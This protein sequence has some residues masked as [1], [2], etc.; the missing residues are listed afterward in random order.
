MAEWI[1]SVHNRTQADV[2]HAIAL[3]KA[4]N[5]LSDHKGCFNVSDIN[6][7]ENNSRY[8][9][10]RLN[11]LKYTNTIET[12]VWDMYGVPNVTEITRLINNVAKIISAYYKPADA[13]NLP[14]TLLTFEQVNA[15]EKNL[16]LIKHLI[17]D[18]E[19]QYRHCGTFNCGEEW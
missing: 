3:L 7:I 8:I 14:N 18:E 17:D 19:N 9:A 10:D 16:Y 1:S 4:G 15:L 2:E 11:V 5:N 12:K 6:R 13:P